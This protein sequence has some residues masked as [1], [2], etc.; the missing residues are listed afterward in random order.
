MLRIKSIFFL[1]L[2]SAGFSCDNPS[3]NQSSGSLS[4]SILDVGSTDVILKL[5]LIDLPKNTAI[6]I[7]RSDS[8]GTS[9]TLA[10]FNSFNGDTLLVDDSLSPNSVFT[11]SAFREMP[12][13]GIIE[14]T[15]TTAPTLDTTGHNIIWTRDYLGDG[16]ASFLS[17]VVI[18]DDTTVIAVGAIY[19]Q[20]STGTYDPLPYNIAKWD[21][22]TWTLDRV[23]VMTGHGQVTDVLFGILAFSRYQIWVTA[24]VP[25]QGDGTNWAVVALPFGFRDSI[26]GIL[27]GI[28]GGDPSSVYFYGTDGAIIHNDGLNWQKVI[29]GTTSNIKDVWGGNPST[30]DQ[31]IYAIASNRNSIGE[32]RILEIAGGRVSGSLSWDTYRSIHSIWYKTKYRLFTSGDGIFISKAGGGWDQVDGISN[33]YATCIRGTNNNDVFFIGAYGLCGHYNGSTCSEYPEL[34]LGLGSYEALAVSNN[35]VVAVGY[36]EGRA[37]VILGQR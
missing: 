16:N 11:Y 18:I 33:Y 26:G 17:D 4:L 21:G 37:V 29:S 5:S 2:I 9:R 8:T 1:L 36:N 34:S 7:I 19:L 35:L 24:G 3:D 30:I 15:T 32:N 10:H 31:P 22:H 25:I 28:W 12:G 14:S 27:T 20:D 6:N 23:T 13:Y